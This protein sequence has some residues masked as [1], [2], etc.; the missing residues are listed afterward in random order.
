MDYKKLNT[1]VGWLVFLIATTVYFITIEDTVSLWDCGEYITAAYKLEVGHPPGAPLFM[2][3]GRLFSFFAAPENVAVWINRMSALSSSATILFMFWSITILTKKMAFKNG[4]TLSRGSQI[5]I[6]GSG[7]VGA[8]AYTFTDSF[9]FSAVEGEVYAMSSLFTALIFWATMKWDEEMDAIKHGELEG[10]HEPMRWM[11]LIMFLFGLAIG[12]HL[13]GLLVIPAIGYVIYFNQWKEISKKGFFITGILSIFVLGFIQEGIIPGTISLASKFE[14]FFKNSMGLPFYSGS[15]FFFILLVGLCVYFLRWSKKKNRPIVNA[16]FLGLIVF[17]IGYGSFAVIVIRSN[18]NTPLDENDPENLVTLHAYLKREQ[19]GSWPIL[20]G[21]YWN[22]D[23]PR[24]ERGDIDNSD[25]GDRS[26]FYARRFVVSKLDQDVKAYRS[27]AKA[28]AYAKKLGSGYEVKEKY[29]VTNEESRKK[30]EPVYAQNTFFPRMYWSQDSKKTNGYK[31]WSGYN[32]NDADADTELGADGKRL[33][34][35]GENLRYFG[36]YQINWMYW[37]YFMWNFAGRQNDIQGHGD[38]MRGNWISGIS[39]IDNMRLGDQSEAPLYTRENPSNNRFFL[40]PLI[41][42]IIGMI[43]HFY[44]APKDAFIVLLTFIFTGL[45]IVIYLNQKP[46]EPRERDYA[47]AASFYAFAMWIGISVYALYEAFKKFERKEYMGL[48]KVIG[49]GFLL[50][51]L[52]DAIFSDNLIATFM[53]LIIS[54]IGAALILIVNLLGKQLKSETS[55]A[56]LAV[57]VAL[58]APVVLAVQ[59]WDDH[60]RSDKTSAHDLAN[61]YLES[62]APN[63][64]LFTNG[65]NDTFPLWYLQE[66]EEKRTDVRVCNLSLMQTDWYTE[67]MM[68]KAYDSDPLPI[69]FEED[70]IMMYAGNTDVVY[71][72]SLLDLVSSSLAPEQLKKIINSK[73]KYNQDSFRASYEGFKGGTGEIAALIKANDPSVQTRV[74][75]IRQSLSMPVT[76]PNADD[77][78][79]LLT[80]CIEIITAYSQGMIEIPTEAIKQFQESLRAWEAPWDYL[81]LAEA[82]EFVRDDHNMI[83]GNIGELRMFPSRGF[84][85]PV[86][87]DNVLKTGLVQKEDLSKVEKELRFKIEKSGIQRE[88]VMMLDIMANN[89]WERNLYFS[90]PGGSDVSMALYTRGYL[91]QNGMVFEVSPIA[92][93]EIVSKD[94]MY[95]N[96]METYAYGKMNQPGVLTDYYTRR[97]T[98]PYRDHFSRLADSYLRDAYYEELNKRRIESQIKSA[99]EMDQPEVA[100]S[101]QKELGK[102][103]DR[104]AEANGRAIKLIKRSVSLMPVNLVIDYG[105]P[106]DLRDEYEGNDGGKYGKYSDGALHEYVG[107]LYRAGDKKA[108]EALGMSVADRIESII[109]YFDHNNAEIAALNTRDFVSALHNYLQLASYAADPDNGAPKGKL[110][111]RTRHYANKIFQEMLPRMYSELKEQ[112]LDEGDNVNIGGET[113]VYGQRYIDFKGHTEAVGVEFGFIKKKEAPS[114]DPAAAGSKLSPEQLRKL[115]EAQQ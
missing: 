20:Y 37:R 80:N 51:L 61:N 66:V 98:G 28:Q 46:F 11:I 63:S 49:G 60:D 15:V 104:V 83:S 17:L 95:K 74:N 86:N 99:K 26:R 22:S 100:D 18:A 73:I 70:Q 111:L 93:R 16:A 72:S 31:Y 75:E 30:Q 77:V 48:A 109:N 71:F 97:H 44:R 42:G 82:M 36:H 27:E 52:L 78:I 65:D 103:K 12:V 40:L 89:D 55:G 33:P 87:K 106:I 81:P 53:W 92:D 105:E 7:F 39:M 90:S 23:Y 67:Q 21:P 8:M 38:V 107:I 4:R 64:I 62:C 45:A 14:V 84:I 19:Y 59:G 34:T 114:T 25:F 50:C 9:W 91:K 1:Y 85:L 115:I 3:L 10:D 112:A 43:F 29:Y 79:K 6:I 35:F 13:L 88:Q 32:A 76:D 56:Y 54:L 47:Y 113:G 5:A 58:L 68:R 96:L 57:I 110:S 108:A 69:K 41:L 94:H 102:I 101:L 2:L 24:N